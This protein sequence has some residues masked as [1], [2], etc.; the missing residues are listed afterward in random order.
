MK[1]T[2][3]ER[4]SAVLVLVDIQERL[5]PV[6]HDAEKVTANARRLCL[7][8]E[9]LAVPTIVTEQI[10]DKLGATLPEV[11]WTGETIPKQHFSCWGA[12]S[13][14]DSLAALGRKQVILA[15]IESQVCVFQTSQDLLAN[16]YEVY[17][18]ADA[19]TS[20][21]PENALL[22]IERMVEDGAKRCSTEMILFSL[23]GEASDPAFKSLLQLVK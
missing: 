19:V 11:G 1:R 17:L 21:T 14:R 5:M 4:H 7:G 9:A 10:P 13:F 2:M 6:M 22:A 12:E 16:G 8:M 3:L 23:L 20:R 15:G 18:V